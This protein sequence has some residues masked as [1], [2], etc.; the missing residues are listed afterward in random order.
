MI[1]TGYNLFQPN[2]NLIYGIDDFR[3]TAPLYPR[4]YAN[5]LR[6]GGGGGKFCTIPEAPDT[7]NQIFDL[8]SVKYILSDHVVRSTE[9]Y[10]QDSRP[11][12]VLDKQTVPVKLADGL[13]FISGSS[14]YD[15]SRRELFA[16]AELTLHD[17]ARGHYSCALG[18]LNGAKHCLSQPRWLNDRIEEVGQSLGA[19]NYKLLFSLPIS[20][21]IPNG[22]EIFAV[23][24]IRDNWTSKLL[25]PP[26]GISIGHFKVLVPESQT[27]PVKVARFSRKAELPGALYLYENRNA[28]PEAYLVHDIISAKDEKSSLDLVQN[29]KLDWK[30]VAIIEGHDLRGSP[31]E[32]PVTEPER[33]SSDSVQV[34]KRDCNSVNIQTQSKSSGWLILTDTFFPGWEANIDGKPARIYPANHMFRAVQIPAG[35]HVVTFKYNPKSFSWGCMLLALTTVVSALIFVLELS[36]TT[37]KKRESIESRSASPQGQSVS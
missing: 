15:V 3:S 30:N 7:L 1:A 35:N 32:L 18:T 2:T 28:T 8:A 5:F 34:T 24:F 14:Y 37:R 31:A 6:L 11:A 17:N 25:G 16:S 26:N 23:I 36:R 33:K 12:V 13:S 27:T 19:H 10:A 21:E 29:K 22:S 4:R 20:S 9:D